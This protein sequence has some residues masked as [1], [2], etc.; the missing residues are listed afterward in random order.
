MSN[1]SESQPSVDPYTIRAHDVSTGSQ[2]RIHKDG[3]T[4]ELGFRG[5]F[6]TGAVYYGQMTRPLVAQYGE[7]WLNRGVVEMAFPKPVL[8]G[9][10]LTISTEPAPHEGRERS[11]VLRGHNEAGVEVIRVGTWLPVPFP[12][13][14]AMSSTATLEWEGEPRTFSMDALEI[15]K[16]FR[17]ARHR[18]SRKDNLFWCDQ[19]GDDL[20]LYR[21]GDA[22]PLH[23][24]IVVRC[25]KNRQFAT[26]GVQISNTLTIHRALR[27]GQ[28][29]ELL[30]IPTEKYEKNG[31]IWVV[32]YN[33]ARVDGVVHVEAIQKK[34]LKLKGA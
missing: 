29:I 4:K 7:D 14:D 25:L 13:P 6:V 11:F 1:H 33:A 32:F 10:L 24:A 23:P 28:E 9:D 16:P 18:W 26:D 34:I 31:N 20:A 12:K 17:A 22:P 21:E 3:L 5:G 2:N 27:V 30:T 19:L 8:E 15:G